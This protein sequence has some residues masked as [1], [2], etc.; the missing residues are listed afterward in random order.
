MM[1]TPPEHFSP[2]SLEKS[3]RLLNHGSTVLISAT[4]SGISN[5]MVA[6]WACVLD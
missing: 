2:V 5:V 6:A 3:Y 4:H 1:T